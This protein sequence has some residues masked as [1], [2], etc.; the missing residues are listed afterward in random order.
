VNIGLQPYNNRLQPADREVCLR[1]NRIKHTRPTIQAVAKRAGV[2]RATVSLILAGRPEVISKF[3]PETVAKVREI[4]AEL[5]YQAN[6]MAVSLRGPH[7]SFFGL[8][9]RGA[10]TADAISW[11]HQAFEGQFLAGALEASR[12]L[13]LYPVLATRIPPTLREAVQSVRGVL[14]GGVFG[15]ILR[16]PVPVLDGPI[17]RLIEQGLPVVTVFPSTRRS[18]HRMG[19]TWTTSPPAASPPSSSTRPADADGSSSAMRSSGEAMPPAEEGAMAVAREV[20]ASADVLVARP[21]S[22]NCRPASG[23]CPCSGKSNP[24]ASTPQHQSTAWPPCWPVW[25]PA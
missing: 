13:K 3:K 21:P 11:Y 24:T 6:L 16:T 23:S 18:A 9:L 5:G 1:L 2:S 15:A 12:L 8:I 19:S 17:R 22:A 14:D 25:Q 4:A 7:P 20:G 10:A